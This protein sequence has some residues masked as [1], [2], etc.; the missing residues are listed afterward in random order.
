MILDKLFIIMKQSIIIYKIQARFIRPKSACVPSTNTSSSYFM[1]PLHREGSSWIVRSSELGHAVTMDCEALLTSATFWNL[2]KNTQTLLPFLNLIKFRLKG[3]IPTKSN[4]SLPRKK[5]STLPPVHVPGIWC[6]VWVL[7]NVMQGL[8]KNNL[9]RKT[10][11]QFSH[12]K[13]SLC[14]YLNWFMLKQINFGS[15]LKCSQWSTS[16]PYTQVIYVNII[17]R[18]VGTVQGDYHPLV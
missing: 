7:T 4:V 9:S 10:I 15:G 14:K 11:E 12:G 8:F 17:S 6:I 3:N 5:I 1:K 16:G 13:L 18:I 2:A